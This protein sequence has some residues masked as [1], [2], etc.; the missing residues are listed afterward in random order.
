MQRIAIL[1]TC[2]NRKEKTLTAL[3][4]IYEAEKAFKTNIDFKVY[5][6]DDGCTDGTGDA[7]HE[8]FPEVI[9]L[10][11]TG[12]LYWAGGM[13]NSWR[14]ALKKNYDAY[15]LLNDDTHTYACLFQELFTTHNYCLNK[16]EQGG[17]YIGSTRDNQT[18]KLSY[19]GAVFINK[20]KAHYVKVI[21]NGLEPQEC[22]LGNA[23]IMLV[24]KDAVDK[25]GMLSEGYVH[26][27][28]DFDYTLKA[29]KAGVPVLIA[30]NFLGDCTN[31]HS[32]T[33]QRFAKLPF[34]KRLKML[35]N[36]I[37][38]DFK[39]HLAYMKNHFP[40]RLPFVFIMGY[41]KV[42]FPKFY[43]NKRLNS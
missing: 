36:P 21:P 2:F 8:K 23:N 22:E 29:K 43:V 34:G 9:V 12:E 41:F 16:Y 28:A 38:L 15:L 30:A 18:Q 10:E 26:G 11:G 6:T 33:Y 3:S 39:S 27:L 37:G 4:D 1:L 35:Y 31:D 14:E 42:F 17:I 32:D 40:Y 19:G 25:I 20:A 5:L 7:V 13:R 24:H